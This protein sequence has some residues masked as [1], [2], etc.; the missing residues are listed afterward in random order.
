MVSVFV[1]ALE[2]IAGLVFPKECFLCS[3]RAEGYFCLECR[4]FSPAIVFRPAQSRGKFY[5]DKI[6]APFI[7]KGRLKE[8]IHMFKYKGSYFFA[9]FFAAKINE[10][11]QVRGFDSKS[12]DYIT[13]VPMPGSKFRQR[14][15][16]QAAELAKELSKMLGIPYKQILSCREGKTSQVGKNRLERIS[17]LSGKFTADTG[18]LED[19]NIITKNDITQTIHSNSQTFISVFNNI[20]AIIG[21]KLQ[22]IQLSKPSTKK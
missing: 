11:L 14:G 1:Q 5:F 19:I 4:S 17:G 2:K 21:Y 9:R 3:S 10:H 15:Y 13:A 18:P 16:N 22:Y 8:A 7:Y 6:W 12:F 20:I